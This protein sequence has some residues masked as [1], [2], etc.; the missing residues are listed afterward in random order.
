M[1]KSCFMALG[2][3]LVLALVFSGCSTRS[4]ESVTF[5]SEYVSLQL[6]GSFVGGDP[7]GPDVMAALEKRAASNP[8]SRQPQLYAVLP[9][10][11]QGRYP[12]A[13]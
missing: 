9:V 1:R 3:F 8:G 6:P 11:S 13:Q 5:H 10:G 7:A 2:T 4:S 12:R